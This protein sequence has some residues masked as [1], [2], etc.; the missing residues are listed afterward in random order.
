MN[1]THEVIRAA[2]S[3][4]KLG[5]SVPCFSVPMKGANHEKNI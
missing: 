2:V 1:P 3:P 5:H 4:G